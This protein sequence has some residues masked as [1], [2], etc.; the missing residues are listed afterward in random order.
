MRRLSLLLLGQILCCFVNC[1][2]A[3]QIVDR[4]ADNG[5]LVRQLPGSEKKAMDFFKPI[6]TEVLS[7]TIIATIFRPAN[8]PRCDGYISKIHQQVKANTPYSSML[9]AVYL[10]SAASQDYIKRN[11]L[12]ADSYL[13]DTTEKFSDFLSFSLGY[14]HV[15]Y[16]LKIVPSTGEVIVGCNADNVSKE[17]FQ[18]LVNYNKKKECIDF[19]PDKNVRKS[20]SSVTPDTLNFV[21]QILLNFGEYGVI[22]SEVIY[23][24]TFYDDHLLLNDKLMLATLEMEMVGDQMELRRIVEPDSI[25]AALFNTLSPDLYQSLLDR[26]EI[27]N[28]PLQ[29]FMLDSINYGIGYSLPELWIEDDGGIA[30][31]NK[32]C[33]LKKSLTDPD[34]SK[35]IPLNYD[36]E[37]EFYYPH[38]TMKAMG[39][40]VVTGAERLTWPLISDTTEFKGKPSMDPFMDSFYTDYRQPTLATYKLSDGTIHKRFG[41]L[42]VFARDAKTGY[43]LTSSVFDSW[44]GEAVF[45]NIYDGRIHI[46]D[47]DDIDCN[48]C[49]TEYTLFEIPEIKCE[50]ES[51][52]Y[53]Y[54][55]A[56]AVEEQLPKRIKEIKSDDRYI[57]CI[58]A[59]NTDIH[60]RPEKE[61]HEYYV[62]DRA[63]GNVKVYSFPESSAGERRIAYGLRRHE[64]GCVEPYFIT[65]L[66]N[67][68]W[69]LRLQ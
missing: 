4:S 40:E 67:G 47:N 44:R 15:G 32:P 54:A 1:L 68:K 64:D 22:P 66:N 18:D 63:T 12:E 21:K 27:K 56:S 28:I 50:D 41:G 23:Q 37:D 51:L 29:S 11:S 43:S 46:S 25:E 3:Q 55:L 49:I 59:E 60:Q 33:I 35:I 57:H 48:E 17:F 38:F 19:Y 30:Y 20:S 39:E 34:F 26:N 6:L 62:I 45:A 52:L 53:S 61:K 16:I 9:I 36:F 7:D 58:V 65:Q 8:C 13:F 42:P 31:R 69:C 24:P 14:L 5:F 2:Y 10:D